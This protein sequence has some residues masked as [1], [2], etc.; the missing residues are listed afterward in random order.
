MFLY[1]PNLILPHSKGRYVDAGLASKNCPVTSRFLLLAGWPLILAGLIS[2][3]PLHVSVA[4]ITVAFIGDH[5]VDPASK[6]LRG[7]SSLS[8]WL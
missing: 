1:V 8:A 3:T 4:P 7:L 2:F 6:G 5:G